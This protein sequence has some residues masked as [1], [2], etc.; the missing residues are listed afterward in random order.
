MIRTDGPSMAGQ[1]R[2]NP[3]YRNPASIQSSYNQ[4]YHRSRSGLQEKLTFNL[5]NLCDSIDSLHKKALRNGFCARSFCISSLDVY[6]LV[7]NQWLIW[8]LSIGGPNAINQ[9][10][11]LFSR[12][13]LFL[14]MGVT[15][16]QKTIFPFVMI[17]WIQF[18]K[19]LKNVMSKC[20]Q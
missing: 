11:F 15:L 1:S 18:F 13:N 2:K 19:M 4:E 5:W 16:L 10:F 12:P 14:S 20:W 17:V 3:Q 6:L 8:K 9:S 7:S